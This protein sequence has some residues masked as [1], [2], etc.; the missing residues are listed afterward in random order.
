MA[1]T[2]GG[3]AFTFYDSSRW[4]YF[5]NYYP[6]M[7]RNYKDWTATFFPDRWGDVSE[8]GK[9]QMLAAQALGIDF[10]NHG[11]LS[12]PAYAYISY[13]NTEEDFYIDIVKAQQD[14]MI[15]YG[16]I[17]PKAYAFANGEAPRTL[18][19]LILTKTTEIKLVNFKTFG[20][21]DD[22]ASS[23]G[24]YKN[25]FPE[26]LGGIGHECIN[27][28]VQNTDH[29][30][31]FLIR[32]L[33]YCRDNNDVY[34]HSGHNIGANPVGDLSNLHSTIHKISRFCAC[35]GMKFYTMRE[36]VDAG[37]VGSELNYPSISDVIITGTQSSGNDLT[38]VPTYQH[39][40]DVAESGT[41][42]QWYRADDDLGTNNAAIGGATSLVYGLTGSDTGKYVRLG[43]IARTATQTG[44]E[45]FT[46]WF[47]IS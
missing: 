14:A 25:F 46:K 20:I 18:A 23:R 5:N 21:F 40:N 1:I 29:D 13:G 42:Y 35:N 7:Q 34:I 36:L 8:L 38:A 27:S 47:A 30:D 9:S 45:T 22:P 6:V 33:E 2:Q 41:T 12:D 24:Y 39:E 4:T 32:Q 17:P 19:N 31:R 16:M 37:F 3:V 10:G 44:I 28:D 11:Y 26:G 43:I 15:T